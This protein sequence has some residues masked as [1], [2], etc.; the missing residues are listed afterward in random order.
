MKRHEIK[1]S[2]DGA[3]ER[4]EAFCTAKLQ[5]QTATEGNQTK[6]RQRMSMTA[7]TDEATTTKG[8]P[9]EGEQAPPRR[10]SSHAAQADSTEQLILTIRAAKGEVIKIEKIEVDGKRREISKEEVTALVGKDELNEIENALDEAFEAGISGVLDPGG[11]VE[12]SVETEE[13]TALRRALLTLI[14]G[15]EVR[16]RLRHRIV[17][18]LILSRATSH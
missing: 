11:E 17:R 16:R 14:V 4:S 7:G 12:E 18:R 3:P 2:V 9:R 1:P 8:G 15:T 13:E 10:E 6:E 5:S